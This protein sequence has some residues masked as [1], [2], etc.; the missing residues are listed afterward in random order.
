VAVS[1]GVVVLL[2]A[3]RWATALR[4]AGRRTWLWLPMLALLLSLLAGYAVIYGSLFNPWFTALSYLKGALLKIAV[5]VA[6]GALVLIVGE[7]V[8]AR[9]EPVSSGVRLWLIMAA[10]LVSG[11]LP[12]GVLTRYPEVKAAVLQ[13]NELCRVDTAFA[14]QVVDAAG[15]SRP[16]Y[17]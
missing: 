8:P 15:L 17:T 16:F 5:I 9:N 7:I 13:F 10:A 6:A 11:V 14:R 4:P 2:P 12:F 3:L 1:T